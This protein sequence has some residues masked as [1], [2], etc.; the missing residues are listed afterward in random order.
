MPITAQ[1]VSKMFGIYSLLR[2][3]KATC[4][5]I[6]FNAA[7]LRCCVLHKSELIA[8]NL[9]SVV[10]YLPDLSNFAHLLKRQS[11]KTR[12]EKLHQKAEK[13]YNVSLRAKQTTTK[14]N[15]ESV[16][17]FLFVLTSTL[18]SGPWQ[19]GWYSKLLSQ[20]K[21]NP[22]I[23]SFSVAES[24]SDHLRALKNPKFSQSLKG[25][26]KERG[27]LLF[28]VLFFVFFAPVLL[29]DFLHL[30]GGC[31]SLT[32]SRLQ[33]WHEEE[34]VSLGARLKIFKLQVRVEFRDNW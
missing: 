12:Y 23:S 31:K 8:Q 15:L 3:N 18:L 25:S 14:K 26:W 20:S 6:S 13:F 16:M 29:S 4:C 34:T 11:L 22:G 2:V 5:L 21:S 17:G 30:V 33:L 24:L 19:K 9:S 32:S 28:V 10:C 27:C 1:F 7:R